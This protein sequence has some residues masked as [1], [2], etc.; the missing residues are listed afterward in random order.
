MQKEFTSFQ[1]RA[2]YHVLGN[3]SKN[4]RSLWF[5]LHGQGQLGQYFAKNFEPVVSEDT[6]VI[7]PEGLS[8]Y[9]LEGF[10]GRVGASW[11]TKE[12]RLTDIENYLTYL[13]SVYEQ[14]LLNPLNNLGSITLLGF[15]QGTATASRWIIT[16]NV[17]FNRLI[18]WAGMFPPDLDFEKGT[19]RLNDVEVL[20]VTGRS[21]QFL[22]K[23]LLIE[24]KELS[25][26]LGITPKEIQFDGGHEIDTK[27]L[28]RIG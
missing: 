28:L 24:Q 11:M 22:T 8:R 9:Y 6:C 23:E 17:H 10:T 27:T 19:E 16:G 18:L 20:S 1:F 14:V 13:D 21:D 4:T 25:T 5:V 15:S 26:K 3:L 12:E 2:R 7:I